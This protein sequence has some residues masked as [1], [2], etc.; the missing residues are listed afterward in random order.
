MEDLSVT[1]YR[2]QLNAE[3]ARR[4]IANPRYSLRAFASF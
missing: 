1:D 2:E 3:L 4:R